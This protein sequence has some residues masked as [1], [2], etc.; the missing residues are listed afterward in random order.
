[1]RSGLRSVAHW[2]GL[3]H[4]AREPIWFHDGKIGGR[5]RRVGDAE[6]EVEITQAKPTGSRLRA[7]RSI[8]LPASQLER[9]PLL[10][11]DFAD[12]A[13]V[14][15]QADMVGLSFAESPAGI[16]ELAR[17]LSK[18][19]TRSIGIVLKIETRRGFDC[20]GWQL[21]WT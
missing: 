16:E 11:K 19:T 4:A 9:P 6:L 8:N 7:D 20:T 10:A 12:L 1:M 21:V 17:E 14:A 3:R 18:R 5:I 13:F 15:E 2:T